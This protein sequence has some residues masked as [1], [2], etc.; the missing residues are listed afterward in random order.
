V[1]AICCLGPPGCS[2][3]GFEHAWLPDA[4]DGWTDSGM[5]A[6]DG[7]TDGGTDAASDAAGDDGDDGPEDNLFCPPLGAPAGPVIQVSPAQAAELQDIVAGAATGTTILLE[8]GTYY[9]PDH[10]SRLFFTQ[11]V[12]ILRSASGNRDAVV[13]DADYQ[14]GILDIRASNVTI[15]DLTL[16]HSLASNDEAAIYATGRSDGDTLGVLLYNIRVV[17]PM[18]ASVVIQY[19]GGTSSDH[20]TIA[21]SSFELSDEARSS[22]PDCTRVRG[23]VSK[24]SSGWTIRDNHFSG[25]WCGSD[26]VDSSA[27]AIRLVSRSRDPV[28]ERNLIV[29]CHYGISLG[30]SQVPDPGSRTYEDDPCSVPG[31]NDFLGGIVRNNFLFGTGRVSPLHDVAIALWNCCDTQVLHNTAVFLPGPQTIASIEWRFSVTDNVEIT[32]NLVNLEMRSRDGAVV[33]QDGNIVTDALDVT[34]LDPQAGDL[35]LLPGAQN[36]AV[37]QGVPVQAG[38]C[39]TDLDGDPRDQSPDVGADEL[40]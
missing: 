28:V 17:D 3:Y 5:D 16:A 14:G 38:L 30:G 31:S 36:P 19:A 34:F 10:A 7:W 40:P 15:A 4:G 22:S 39:D 20:G 32:N 23:I 1:L 13:L 29:D 33:S 27:G 11:D 26:P 18:S 25:F 6:G 9:I 8:D 24:G 2:R 37:D 35:H 12:V 21:C